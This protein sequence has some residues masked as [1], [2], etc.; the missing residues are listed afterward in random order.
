MT[1][2][3]LVVTAQKRHD[4]FAC[5][6][7]VGQMS[8]SVLEPLLRSPELFEHVEAL[9][10]VVIAEQQ[11]RR[12]FYED[13]G[14]DKKWEFINGQVVVHS[15]ATN[16]HNRITAR[17]LKLLAIWVDEK[18]LGQVTCEKTLCRFPRNDY[19]PDIVFY[20][21]AKAA[22][23]EPDTLLHPIPDMIV[24]VLSPT[25]EANDRGV[26]FEDFQAHGVEEY[27][28]VDPQRET[29]EQHL[30]ENGRYV[31]QDLSGGEVASRAVAGFQIPLRAIFEDQ[32]NALAAKR[33]L[34]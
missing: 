12:K 4:Q 1:G 10:R 11:R 19:E 29:V 14:P 27:W 2:P 8:E 13:I 5:Y 6:G 28:L 25:T 33:L 22:Q 16:Q 34:S 26:K 15:P 20:G 31:R 24:E 7:I 9:N 21:K 32:A 30:L 17:L 18:E 23:I 3:G